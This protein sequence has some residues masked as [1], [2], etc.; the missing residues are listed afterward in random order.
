MDDWQ[1]MVVGGTF[2]DFKLPITFVAVIDFN[3]FFCSSQGR[4]PFLIISVFKT[5]INVVFILSRS[6]RHS[7][8]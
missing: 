5:N 7:G 1:P 8:R 6:T 3:F 2:S 4:T